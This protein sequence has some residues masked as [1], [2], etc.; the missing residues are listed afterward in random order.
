MWE[1]YCPHSFIGCCAYFQE[2]AVQVPYTIML[3]LLARF[4]LIISWEFPGAVSSS[5]S[6][7]LYL[8]I[9]S[10]LIL[11]PY[12]IP[13]LDLSCYPT[14][15]LF[16]PVPSFCLHQMFN[17]AFSVR[18]KHPPLGPSYYL[19]SFSLWIKNGKPYKGEFFVC[20]F[21][22]KYQKTGI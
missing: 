18:F 11:S 19:A 10:L 16:F 15:P 13:T 3:G 8:Q 1:G 5:P 9:L 12:A 14:E 21:V 22:F 7:S 17:V 4:N 2:E 6:R 20:L